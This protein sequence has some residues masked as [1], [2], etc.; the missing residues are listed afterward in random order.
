MY[1]PFPL[2]PPSKFLPLLSHAARQELTSSISTTPTKQSNVIKPKSSVPP[3]PHNLVHFATGCRYLPPVKLDAQRCTRTWQWGRSDEPS[4]GIIEY[5]S[6]K[7]IARTS[8]N[9]AMLMD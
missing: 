4:P 9:D 6:G 7:F 1:E 2:G 3:S 5:S 8:Y